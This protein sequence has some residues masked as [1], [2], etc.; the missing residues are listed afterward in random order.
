MSN[1]FEPGPF[2]QP[3]APPPQVGTPDPQGWLASSQLRAGLPGAFFF[4]GPARSARSG[5][6]FCYCLRRSH[7]VQ[8]AVS[9][10]ERTLSGLSPNGPV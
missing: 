9:A 3:P 1:P 6:P 7:F 5:T 10:F 2:N 4:T 8:A